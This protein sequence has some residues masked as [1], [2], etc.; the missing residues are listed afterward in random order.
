MNR[1][2]RLIVHDIEKLLSEIELVSAEIAKEREAI[3]RAMFNASLRHYEYSTA[4]RAS[5]RQAVIRLQ[6]RIISLEETGEELIEKSE[7]IE[8]LR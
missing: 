6:T 7:E 3:R 8:V 4:S 1:V 2:N 5:L